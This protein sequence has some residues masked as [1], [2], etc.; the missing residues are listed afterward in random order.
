MS[1]KLRVAVV[2]SGIGKAHAVAFARLPDA[3]TL[4]AI[5]DVNVARA[6]ELA[7]TAHVAVVCSDLDEVCRRDDIDVVDLCTPPGLHFAQIQQV[8]AAGK[9]CI[10]EKPL[11]GSLREVDALL[12][13]EERSGKRMMPI[14]QYRYGN[15]LQKLKLLIDEG[16][17]GRAYVSTIEMAWRRRMDYYAVPWRS[18]WAASLGGTLTGHAIHLLDMLTYVIGPVQDVFARTKTLV[19]PIE[20][21]DCA[22]VSLEMAD[23]SL[24]AMSV[25]VGSV[26]QV[27]RHRICF[28]NMVAESNRGAYGASREPWTFVGDTPQWQ[29]RIDAT[30]A[31]F[32]PLPEGFEGQFYYFAQALQTGAELPVTL[33]DARAAVELLTALYKSSLTH[34]PVSLPLKPDEW[35][36]GW[37]PQ[38][39]AR[40][41]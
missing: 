21:E 11:V 22:A 14:F 5:C 24:V 33:H 32:T 26:E 27:S 4:A 3:F 2:G 28:S 19:N 16:V 40:G 37:I 20:V 25:T 41:Q 13:A 39:T 1:D 29:E 7:E 31:H 38:M 34:L 6:R 9:H 30:L 35:Y 18:T 8:L 12:A 36:D 17:A 10:C 15:G 23:G